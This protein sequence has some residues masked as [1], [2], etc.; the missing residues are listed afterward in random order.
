MRARRSAAIGLL[1]AMLTVAACAGAPPDR[2]AEVDRL[3]GQIRA[4]PG[5]TEALN[6]FNDNVPTGPSYFELDLKVAATITPDQLVAITS[7]YL[8]GLAASD[9]NGYRAE[10]D[11]RTGDNVFLVDSSGRPVSNRDQILG[12]ARQWV[13]LRQ[14]FVGSNV[15]LRVT[16]S[17]AGDPPARTIPNS[18]TIQL[19]DSA[20][21]VAV[22]AAVDRLATGFADLSAGEWTINAGRQHSAEIHTLQRLPNAG[23]LDLWRTLNADQ[24]IP[25][26]NVFTINNPVTAPLW[27]AE[28]T[29]AD[30]KDAALLLAERHLPLVARLPAPVLYTA[31]NQYRGHIGFYGQA[32][33]PVAILIG[34]CIKRDY[35]PAPAE[36]ALIDRYEN[37]R[38]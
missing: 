36:Q 26:S 7:T 8:D 11:V 2:R 30:D 4:L 25:H 33:G 12:Q 27:V 29:P 28:K 15:G 6:T 1:L 16:I 24:A 23:E 32:T 38:R 34:G 14:Q 21:Y 17:H 22:A 5:V 37:C 3:T 13:A 35:R 9:F 10:M 18:G 20:D 31:S 19:P